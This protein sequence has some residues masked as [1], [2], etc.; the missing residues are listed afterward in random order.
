MINDQ[1]VAT[2]GGRKITKMDVEMFLQN[3]DQNTAA[4][5]STPDGVRQ[6]IV[7]LATQELFFLD[8]VEKGMDKDKEYIDTVE[9]QKEVILKQYALGKHLNTA[10]VSEEEMRKYYEENLSLFNYPETVK[11]SH[12]L[13]ETEDQGKA[14]MKRLNSGDSFDD[15]A[16]EF[17]KCPS[18]SKGGDLGYFS[19][20][21]MV[22][23]FEDAAF[24]LV[25]GEVTSGPVK[26]QF[27]FHIIKLTDK[28]D[29]GTA[30]FEEAKP[31][32]YQHL[33]M[34]KQEKLYHEKVDELSK[35]YE[36]VMHI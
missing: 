7:Q 10:T 4:R 2:V 32:I 11:A 33:I 15:V 34:T 23:E 14:A 16:K 1:V 22:K 6:L 12:I 25:K 21:K 19:R 8:A 29:A 27:G 5:F 9:K 36:L 18:S 30:T 13:T 31:K 35:K 20:G 17:S 24:S 26:T 28:K 3:A